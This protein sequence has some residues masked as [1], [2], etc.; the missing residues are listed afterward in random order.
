DHYAYLAIIGPI[1]IVAGALMRA[2]RATATN[3]AMH[4]IVPAM[5]LAVLA[6]LTWGRGHAYHSAQ[7]IWKDVLRKNPE[8]WMAHNNLG[9]LLLDL[10]DDRGAIEHFQAALALRP[11]TP[12]AI[13]NI[14]RVWEKRGAL[15]LAIE[16]YERS[17]ATRRD[18]DTGWYNLGR[19][20]TIKGD[21]AAA[22]AAYEKA[23]Q[24]NPNHLLA[25]TNLGVL[26]FEQR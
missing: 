20:L 1:A 18:Y 4:F 19:A 6:I 2:W 26:L 14:G 16:W 8:S 24:I 23:I 11:Q 7:S 17:V 10:D 15:D 22:M 9:A 21:R 13:A 25:R 5:I 3:I 12:E